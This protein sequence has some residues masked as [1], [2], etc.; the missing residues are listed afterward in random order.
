MNNSD[1]LTAAKL[2]S[3]SAWIRSWQDGI[4][5][6]QNQGRPKGLPDMPGN[7]NYT[8]TDKPLGYNP[9]FIWNNN[10]VAGSGSGPEFGFGPTSGSAE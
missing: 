9:E 3:S 6:L 5:R 7:A 10:T 8:D 4:K 2:A 1:K